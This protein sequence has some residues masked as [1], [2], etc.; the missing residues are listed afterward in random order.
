MKAVTL[1]ENNYGSKGQFPPF[2][3]QWLNMSAPELDS[4]S[5]IIEKIN[6]YL[7]AAPTEATCLEQEIFHLYTQFYLELG[8]LK[9][10]SFMHAM[11][12]FRD[13][14]NDFKITDLFELDQ[15]LTQVQQG[16]NRRNL[17]TDIQRKKDAKMGY[18]VSLKT[19]KII[20][21]SQVENGLCFG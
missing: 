4:S 19:R 15:I 16:M 8:K 7:I 3:Q 1:Q 10:H 20:P 11:Q 9:R 2:M 18:V 6:Q 13:I 5:Q 12:G 21:S 14:A 17:M